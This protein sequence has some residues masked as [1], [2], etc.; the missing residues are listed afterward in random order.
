M[1]SGGSVVS[2]RSGTERQLAPD[3]AGMLVVKYLARHPHVLEDDDTSLGIRWPDGLGARV[4]ALLPHNAPP[5][6]IV[7][8]G[9]K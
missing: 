6:G 1:G 5:L 8:A 7:V 2:P 4:I 3:H 9:G